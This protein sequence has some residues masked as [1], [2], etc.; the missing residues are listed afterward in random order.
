MKTYNVTIKIKADAE[1]IWSILTDGSKYAEWNEA[2]EKV[3]GDI[4]LGQRIKV[5]A[6]VSPGRA[7]PVTVVGFAPGKE[8]IWLGGMPLGVFKGIRTF[9]LVDERN[10]IVEFG[11]HEVFSGIMSPLIL[12]LMPDL[13]ESF[14]Q[15]AAGLKR[16]A[17]NTA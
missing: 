5:Y 9:T 11:M 6:K 13:T 17:E 4:S 14:A 2:V 12:R 1:T 7:F 10:G 15:F 3:E 8:M 16:K